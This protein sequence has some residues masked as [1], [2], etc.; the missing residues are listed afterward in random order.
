MKMLI[1]VL[2]TVVILTLMV[3]VLLEEDLP[4]WF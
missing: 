3:F 4:D 1:A 2:F